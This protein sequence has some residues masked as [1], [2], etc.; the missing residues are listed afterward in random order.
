MKTESDAERD[1]ENIKV[2]TLFH[3]LQVTKNTRSLLHSSSQIPMT[4]VLTGI[5]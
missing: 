3:I 5:L 4:V 2:N 1:K